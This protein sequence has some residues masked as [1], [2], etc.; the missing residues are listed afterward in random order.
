MNVVN[1][2]NISKYYG[3]KSVVKNVSFVIKKGECFG[4]LGHNGAGKTTIVEM[5]LGLKKIEKGGTIQLLGNDMHV[6]RRELFN[7]V[8]AQLQDSS[9]PYKIKVKEACEEKAVLYNCEIDIETQLKLFSLFDLK[10][11]EV[12]SL[13]GGERQ[14]LSILLATI[15]DPAVLFLDELTT[16]LDAVARR[17]IW[18]YL[19]GLKNKGTTIILT[20]HFMD[21]VEA[22]CDS[23]MLLR[24]G[25][26]LIQGKVD[27]V[28][29]A[30]PYKTMEEA[31][32]WY[33]GEDKL[34]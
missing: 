22:L 7:L 4:I 29:Q 12:E 24:N 31:Y 34:L 9:Y 19:N 15:H 14:R 1:V 21:E 28:I 23:V 10:N 32:L 16:G 18:K 11:R 26:I 33:M 20:S 13:S 3:N 8:G 25:E 27:E 17:E 2:L 5:I 30:T 6:R